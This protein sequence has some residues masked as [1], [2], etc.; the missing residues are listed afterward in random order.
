M[1]RL[2]YTSILIALVATCASAQAQQQRGGSA[3]QIMSSIPADGETI[4]HWYKQNVYDPQ[5]SKIGE[6]MDVLVDREGKA[7]A[8]I[9]GVGGFLGAGEKDVAVPFH[10]VQITNKNNNKW[11]L[12]MNTT[13]DALKNA[14]GFKYDRSAMKWEPE[15]SSATTGTPAGSSQ[16]PG[17]R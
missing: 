3:A 2:A 17:N 15:E 1:A 10:A 13:K 4:T 16:R 14:K 9:V 12:V 11:Y 8:L 5:D 7:T 6:V